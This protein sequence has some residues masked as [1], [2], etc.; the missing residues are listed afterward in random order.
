MPSTSVCHSCGQPVI[1]A[2]LGDGTF[3]PFD[4]TRGPSAWALSKDTHLKWHARPLAPGQQPIPGAE[5]RHAM[6][7]DTCT[8]RGKAGNHHAQLA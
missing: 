8:Q 2:S 1:W 4:T 6:H 7:F 3:K 5:H